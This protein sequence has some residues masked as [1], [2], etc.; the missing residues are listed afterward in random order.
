MT[1]RRLV[2]VTLCSLQIGLG[3]RGSVAGAAEL[4]AVGSFHG[5]EVSAKTGQVWYG[6]Y[7]RQRGC[8]L[9]ASKIRVTIVKDEIV[10]TTTSTGKEVQVD[11]PGETLF[12]VRGVAGLKNRAV[13][14]SY[15]GDPAKSLRPGQVLVLKIGHKK[16]TLS[17]SGKFSDN[18]S[19]AALAEYK[20]VLSVGARSQTIAAEKDCDAVHPRLIWAGDLDSD[21]RIDLL[22]DSSTHYNVSS[23]TL[24]LS[25]GATGA[26]LVRAAAKFVTSGC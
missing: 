18:R 9:K 26:Q 8:E 19:G 1:K 23:R 3:S 20:L 10:D 6:L 13:A 15:A 5:D 22:V 25:E 14:T 17:V 16:Y 21:G 24:W 11:Q 2:L 7:Q 4:L 12:L